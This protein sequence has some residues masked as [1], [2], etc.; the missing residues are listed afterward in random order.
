MTVVEPHT[1]VGFVLSDQ[2]LGPGSL[3]ARLCQRLHCQP[4]LTRQCSVGHDENI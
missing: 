4:W 2:A 3:V 1:N